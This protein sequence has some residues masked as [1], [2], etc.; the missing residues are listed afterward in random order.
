MTILNTGQTKDQLLADIQ[1]ALNNRAYTFGTLAVAT[2]PGT[3]GYL[4]TT[5][6]VQYCINGR[7]YNKT[8][9]TT[10]NMLSGSIKRNGVRVS[11]GG[12]GYAIGDVLNLTTTGSVGTVVV[13]DVVMGAV[14][15]VRLQ[16]AGYSYT[17]GL[18]SATT[19]NFSP[20]GVSGTGCTVIIADIEAYSV[21]PISTFCNFL[22]SLTSTGVVVGTQGVATATDTSLAPIPNLPDLPMGTAPFGVITVA[23]DATHTF[24]KG[25][26]GS[27]SG[28]AG[29]TMTYMDLSSM[30]TSSWAI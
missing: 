18:L 2:T 29:I 9:I 26:A 19:V 15:E 14:T 7:F 25:A 23:T 27:Y 22:L 11:A 17:S 1:Q 28:Q 10:G 8:A 30:L 6:T 16:A 12:T 21:Q 24:T 20:T 4:N 5:T 3:A 13:S